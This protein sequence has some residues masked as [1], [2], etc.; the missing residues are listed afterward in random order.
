MPLPAPELVNGIRQLMKHNA[1][2]HMSYLLG[3]FSLTG[4]WYYYPV[5]L[6]VKTPL[7]FLLLLGTGL[8]LACRKRTDAQG[9]WLPLAFAA[10]IL[11][12]AACSRINIGVRHILPVYMAFSLVSAV[13]A[14]RLLREAPAR[15]W[16]RYG[17][18]AAA[19]WFAASSLASHPDYLAYTN[20]LAGSEP[21]KVLADSDL[22]WGQDA[23]RLSARLRELGAGW[24]TFA[25]FAVADFVK[26]HGFP[27]ALEMNPSRPSAG[28]NAVSIS[29]WKVERFGLFSEHPEAT[30]WPDHV[31]PTERVG[32][33][34]LLYY[35]PE[36]APAGR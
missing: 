4:F 10:G 35:F 3:K 24:V 12:T 25:P 6:A 7:G 1:E 13:A 15:K 18:L 17:L 28:W 5:V 19:V 21:E 11:L 32:K 33:S 14:I 2:G 9:A 29:A 27:P 22:D 31:K 23:K 34:I 26:E 36:R 8:A 30:F 16:V 20:E